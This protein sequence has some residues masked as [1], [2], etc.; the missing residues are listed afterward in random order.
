MACSTSGHELKPDLNQRWY[1]LLVLSAF[2]YSNHSK[3]TQMEDSSK[4]RGTGVT[5]DLTSHWGNGDQ[6]FFFFLKKKSSELSLSSSVIQCEPGWVCAPCSQ[7][8]CSRCMDW[9]YRTDH[10]PGLQRGCGDIRVPGTFLSHFR[11][12]DVPSTDWTQ[13]NPVEPLPFTHQHRL[14]LKGLRVKC[15][16]KGHADFLELGFDRLHAGQFPFLVNLK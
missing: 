10:F 15:S 14:S 11:C 2:P 12:R 3:W 1:Q 5:R 9:S 7:V 13:R 8:E 4:R 6:L 16:N